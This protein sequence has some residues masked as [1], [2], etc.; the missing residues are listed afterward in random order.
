[1]LSPGFW[2]LFYCCCWYPLFVDAARRVIR[3]L[4]G[5]FLTNGTNRMKM[6]LI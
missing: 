2:Q 1:M 6:P 4:P 5:L 3:Y